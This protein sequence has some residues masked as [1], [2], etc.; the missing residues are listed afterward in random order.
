MGNPNLHH[1]MEISPEQATDLLISLRN[2]LV[3]LSQSL[4][5]LLFIVDSNS[6]RAAA[7]ATRD[8]LDRV[9]R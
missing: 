4:S 8:V 9:N 6:R 5:D 3:E 1:N 7:E 2:N